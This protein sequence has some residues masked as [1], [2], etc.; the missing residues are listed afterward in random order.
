M[1]TF[2]PVNV[3][4]LVLL[5]ST[6]GILLWIEFGS[7]KSLLNPMHTHYPTREDNNVCEQSILLRPIPAV[8][9]L[10]VLGPTDSW[11]LSRFLC[12]LAKD[13][14]VLVNFTK[15]GMLIPHYQLQLENSRGVG[16]EII[17]QELEIRQGSQ[18]LVGV[19]ISDPLTARSLDILAWQQ[20]VQQLVT[21]DGEPASSSR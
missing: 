12:S 13:R 21:T 4:I 8:T 14:Y 15:Q 7:A 20:L 16:V 18:A 11:P 3:G 17:L 1:H 6:V 5:L 9:D 10:Q 19:K 2:R